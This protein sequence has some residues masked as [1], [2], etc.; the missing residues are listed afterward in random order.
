[1]TRRLLTVLTGLLTLLLMLAIA[2]VVYAQPSGA[3]AGAEGNFVEQLT[4][5]AFQILTPVATVFVMW[6]AHRAI[7]AFEKRSGIEIPAKQELAIDGW[8]SQG[9]LWAEETSRSAIKSRASKLTGPE[10]LETAG[11]FVI[12]MVRAQGWDTWTANAV[13]AKIEAK[14]GDQRANGSGKPRLDVDNAPDHPD[15]GFTSASA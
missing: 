5:M 12:D 13:R 1:M 7:A 15:A 3:G 4:T 14:L 2:G 10:K 8:I 9:I 6:A 11:E